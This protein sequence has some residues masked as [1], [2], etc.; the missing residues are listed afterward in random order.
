MLN[1]PILKTVYVLTL[2]QPKA[3][4]KGRPLTS[5]VAGF[6]LNHAFNVTRMQTVLTKLALFIEKSD[7]VP[8]FF[9]TDASKI[10]QQTTK[11]TTF[12]TNDSESV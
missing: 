7:L 10:I 2:T 11:Q 12:V 8:H 5:S 3:L 1:C 4:F 9:V 6:R